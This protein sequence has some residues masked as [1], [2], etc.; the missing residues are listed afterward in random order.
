MRLRVI[1]KLRNDPAEV[2]RRAAL[3]FISHCEHF[4]SDNDRVFE[5]LRNSLSD[6]DAE[7]RCRALTFWKTLALTCIDSCVSYQDV[8]KCVQLIMSAI[9]DCESSVRIEALQ[10]L[11][12]VKDELGTKCL[13]SRDAGVNATLLKWN[14]ANDLSSLESVLFDSDWRG[15]FDSEE[16]D[17]KSVDSLQT[18]VNNIISLLSVD[19]TSCDNVVDC[20]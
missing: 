17:S 2:V 3:D 4:C 10:A 7:V 5:A 15:R 11:S 20:Y 12:V 18:T 9:D 1:Y 13:K 19:A 14:L 16:L 8:M 6:V